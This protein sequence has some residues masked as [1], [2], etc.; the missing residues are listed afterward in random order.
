MRRTSVGRSMQMAGMRADV[1]FRRLSPNLQK[2]AIGL[3][4]AGSMYGGYRSVKN[5]QEGHY[6]KAAA[7]GIGAG[8]LGGRA[9]RNYGMR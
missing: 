7:W 3:G 1:G 2:T 5:A 8:L 9:Y 4:A 6:G